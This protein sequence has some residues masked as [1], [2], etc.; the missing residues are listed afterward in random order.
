MANEEIRQQLKLLL[1]K[2]HG[3]TSTSSC[4]MPRSLNGLGAKERWDL[5]LAVQCLVDIHALHGYRDL[6]YWAL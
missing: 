6:W 1:E 4:A 5:H 2:G 3:W